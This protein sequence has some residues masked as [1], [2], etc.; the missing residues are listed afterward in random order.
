MAF[1]YHQMDQNH[2]RYADN[3]SISA[4]FSIKKVDKKKIIILKNEAKTIRS[5]KCCNNDTF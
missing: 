2:I 4:S 5:Y 1:L 3:F